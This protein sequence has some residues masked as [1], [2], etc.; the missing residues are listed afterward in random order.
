MIIFYTYLIAFLNKKNSYKYFIFSCA[1]DWSSMNDFAVVY[2]WYIL[3][4]G[5]FIPTIV[6][7]VSNVTVLHVS[8][9]VKVF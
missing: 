5:F 9:Q 2:N 1:P 3:I 6:V 4:L 8:R 7:F